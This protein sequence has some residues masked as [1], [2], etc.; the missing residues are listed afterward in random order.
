M[1]NDLKRVTRAQ[2]LPL[3]EKQ[4]KDNFDIICLKPRVGLDRFKKLELIKLNYHWK[5]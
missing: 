2:F 1:P 3:L 5:V 4:N